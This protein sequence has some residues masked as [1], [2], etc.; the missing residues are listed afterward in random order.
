ME[1]KEQQPV[2]PSRSMRQTVREVVETLVLA[3]LIY[4]GVQTVIPPYAV[5][6]ASMNPNLQDG[7]RLLINR[8]VYTHFDLNAVWN[9]IPGVDREGTAVVYP[10]HA[11][12]R[13]D[14]VVLE[15]PVTSDRPYIKRVIGLP[16][17]EIA[18]RDGYVFINGD[19]LD[20][21]YLDGSITTCDGDRHCELT[22]PEGTVYVLGDNRNNSADSRYF[23][24]VSLNAIIGKAWI[25]NWPLD[26]IGFIPEADYDQSVDGEVAVESAAAVGTPPL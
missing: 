13:G 14:I 4:F 11:P 2:S 19:Q 18:F 26:R 7:E 16:G 20:E 15:P 12:E 22:V 25:A 21:A 9:I 3:A 23:G 5:D 24:P 8:P 1:D 17:D 10:F 6:G